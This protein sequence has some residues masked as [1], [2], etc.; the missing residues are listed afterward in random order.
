M[1]VSRALR[2]QTGV[3]DE[4]RHRIEQAA[5]DLGYRRSPLV[6]AFLSQI[7]SRRTPAT[8]CN[9]AFIQVGPLSESN[10]IFRGAHARALKLGYHLEGVS[11]EDLHGAKSPKVQEILL[12][13][14]VHG[15]VLNPRATTFPLAMEWSKFSLVVVG[16]FGMELQ[17]PRVSHADFDNLILCFEQLRSRG[18][19]RIGIYLNPYVDEET[20]REFSGAWGAC[21]MAIVPRD[22]VSPIIRTGSGRE[23]AAVLGRWLEKHKI[24]GLIVHYVEMLSHLNRLGY[25]VPEQIQVAHLHIGEDVEDWSG[26]E[27]RYEE[28]G[29]CAIDILASAVE[30]NERGLVES[31]HETLVFGRWHEGT[32][33]KKCPSKE[34]HSI[35]EGFN[36]RLSRG[37]TS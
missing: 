35:W 29:A 36:E 14:G 32:T 4:M 25:K 18:C 17:A 1:T 11:L 6:G 8:T 3:G 5:A 15:L 20:R 34:L 26:I 16:R 28:I 33:T 24:D 19:R 10:P 22:R 12:N 13:R 2:G 37:S 21:Q 30:R 23:A 7:R 31:P 9:L 27:P